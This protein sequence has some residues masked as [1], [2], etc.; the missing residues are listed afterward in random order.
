MVFNLKNQVIQLY[1]ATG[2]AQPGRFDYTKVSKHADFPPVNT[3]DWSPALRGLVAVGT[4]HGDVH[5]LRVD[6]H[7][8]ARFTLPLKLQRP[9]LS[10]AFNTE[11]LLAV[12]L[13]RVRNDSCLQV[14]DINQR[15]ADWNPSKKGWDLPPMHIEPKKK[16]EGSTSITSIRFFEDQPQTLVAGV[17]NQSVRVHDLRDPNSSVITF[18]TRC[19][20]NIA[21]DFTDSNYFASSTLDQPGFVVWDKRVAGR[22]T[23]SPMYLESFD[24]EEITW[25][26][27]LKIDRAIQSDKNTPSSIK[28]LRY[29]R[30]QRGALGVLS[31]AGQLQILQT[32]KEYIE[33]G[34][35]DDVKGSPQLLEI[36]K[37]YDLEY[38]YFDENHRLKHDHRIVSFDWINVGTPEL[39]GRVVAL[40]G[41]G[42][43]EVLQMP[44]KT[45]N[46]VVQFVPWEPPHHA[47]EP[48]LA[49]L[50]FADVEECKKVLGPICASAAEASIPVFGPDSLISPRVISALGQEI[51]KSLESPGDLVIDQLAADDTSKNQILGHGDSSMGSPKNGVAKVKMGSKGSNTSLRGEVPVLELPTKKSC[52]SRELHDKFH[53]AAH[54][55]HPASKLVHEHLDHTVLGRAMAGYLFDCELNKKIVVEDPWLKGVWE[56]V[57]GAEELAKHDGMVSAPID[58]SYM[59][60]Y[61][62]WTNDLG[63][64]SQSR[65]IDSTIIPDETQ[66]EKLTAVIN[67]H[68]ARPDFMGI[69][70][71]KP[72]H[73]QLCL[74]VSGLLKSPS[75]LEEDLRQLEEE[76]KVTTAA[77][78]AL[79]EGLPKRAVQIL[80][81]GGT[82][83][84]FVAMALD[85]KLK[86]DSSLDLEDA[87]WGQSLENHPQ[88]AADPYLR[89]IYGYITTGDW[90]AIADETALP[91]RDRV[92]VALRNFDDDKLTSWLEKEME[93]AIQFGDIE[94][95]VL[96]GITDNMVDIFSKYVEKFS[97]HQTP[98]LVMSYCYPRYIDDIRCDAWRI[99]YRDFLQRHR[100]FILRVKF[101]QQSSFKSRKRDGAPVIKPPPRQVTIRCLNCDANAANDLRNSGVASGSASIPSATMVDPRN[102]LAGTGINAGLCCPKCGAHLPRCSVC[103]EI[104]GVPRSDRP[105]MSVNEEVHRMANFPTFCLKCKHVMHMDHSLAWFKRHVECPVAECRCQCNA[106][107]RLREF[108]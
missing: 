83:L 72:H 47:D 38:P 7:S 74:A 52:S 102:P 55:H 76:G 68:A 14:W 20:N 40:R 18:Q 24:Q 36:R 16:L 34:S 44:A 37:S 85:I 51:R 87:A 89:A 3:Y 65:L 70:T 78:W 93:S 35:P 5:L 84:L 19:C 1:E 27:A 11:G 61:T 45:A 64:K 13:D 88:M 4:S 106:E 104:V 67:R 77:A 86:S 95:I 69:K 17:K 107:A 54:R 91:L 48:Y 29:S 23:A 30:E 39:Q 90:T 46:Q 10:V 108:E 50:N 43:F 32:K 66:W 28:Q 73:R 105:E 99:A 8:N 12:G 33:P 101:E 58:L 103:M 96:A 57:A 2:Y 59:G 25:G 9:V 82:D 60:V 71:A 21:I 94:G 80:K 92:G 62:I 63:E 98:I 81:N 75:E 100:K 41:N 31:N 97:D 49:L 56:W 22:S 79:F 42:D 26:A 6:D 15:L 53:Y